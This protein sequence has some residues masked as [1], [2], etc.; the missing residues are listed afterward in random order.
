MKRILKAVL[1]IL[2]VFIL[3][4]GGYVAYLLIDYHRLPDT[5]ETLELVGE[6]A[7]T[8]EVYEIV[9][10]NLGFG[11]YSSDFGFF[12]DGGTESRARS[13][14]AVYDNLNHAAE[15]LEAENPDFM[16][17]QELDVDATRT[18]HVDERALMTD[19]FSD[20]QGCFAMNYDSGY[21]F[22][23]LMKPHGASKAGILT[24]SRRAIHR[25]ARVSLPVETGLT[26]FL[27]L[28]RC[29]SKAYLPVENGKTLCL[30][31]LHLSAY[32]S[33]GT[34]ATEQ[35]RLLLA[36]MREEYA[37][38]NYVVGG[39]D[40]NK[41]LLGNSDEIFGVSGEAYTWAQPLPED[42][43]PEGLKLVNSLDANAPVPS[44]RNADG[45]Y[46]PGVSFVLT[47]DGF[48]TSDNVKAVS[49]GVMD[50]GFAVSD[51]NPVKMTFELMDMN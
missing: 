37:A 10:W 23:P 35:L 31:N 1:V 5:D 28:D 29:Y 13:K 12:M 3:V 46:Q 16:L 50:E 20:W 6:T 15:V 32:T 39:G 26:R 25:F 38:G 34:I 21:L 14:D 4:V 41:D 49:C 17:L 8:G 42:V 7:R 33:D 24:L 44:C 47:V 40:F 18:Y 11:A 27:D 9:T 48:I 19:R 51:H 43:F 36:D 2:L 30:Y 45:P 22:Y